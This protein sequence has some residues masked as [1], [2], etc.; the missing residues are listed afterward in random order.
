MDIIKAY[1][2]EFIILGVA[3]GFVA[4]ILGTVA[5]YGIIVGIMEMDWTF[6]IANSATNGH[7]QYYHYHVNWHVQHLESNVSETCAGVTRFLNHLFK[8]VQGSNNRCFPE[9]YHGQCHQN[10]V[11]GVWA[12]PSRLMAAI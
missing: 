12:L 10:Y 9:L 7:C 11:F 8:K 2:F 6:L 3:T 1:V 4:I 5:S